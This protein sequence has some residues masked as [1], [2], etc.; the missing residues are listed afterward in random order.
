MLLRDEAVDR[1]LPHAHD[2]L[3]SK[4]LHRLSRGRSHRSAQAF[5]GKKFLQRAGECRNL[6]LAANEEPVDT[7]LDQLVR[8]GTLSKRN[9]RRPAESAS[10]KAL[11]EALEAEGKAKMEAEL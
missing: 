6:V 3:R 2:Y 11:G 5:R 9:S 7:V 8:P 10:A 4:L 1:A